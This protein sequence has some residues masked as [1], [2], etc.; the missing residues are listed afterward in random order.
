MKV[1]ISADME[2]TAGIVDSAQTA[3]PDR[4]HEFGI[5]NSSAEFE[6]ARR[7]M[8][9]E[10]NAAVAGALEGGATEVWVTDAHGSMRNL[11]PLALH[12]E[13]RYVGGRP[14][15]L[16]QLEGLDNT[17]GAVL[18]TGYHGRAGTP[19]SILAHTYIGI[20]QGIRL[21]GV[22]V[23]E[24]GVNA[25]LAGYF[26]V[27]VA[28]VTGDNTVVAQVRDLLGPDVVGVEV[29][30]A[31][32]TTAAASLHPEKARAAIRAGAAEAVR[33][34]PRLRPFLPAPPIRLEVDVTKPDLADLASL[35]KGVRR[36]GSHGIAYE[37]PDMMDVWK[38][39]L[40][41]RN[42]MNSRMP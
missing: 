4:A 37:G 25:A 27:P 20:I 15:L 34:A 2:G 12:P 16:G 35:C 42:V 41:M 32:S 29:K 33:R 36:T 19:A 3:P 28:L 22:P 10:A 11:L 13:A 14:K 39:W 17:F 21:G 24:Y 9:E 6:W 8:T 30:K 26:G 1:L 23:G 31:V 5:Q 38:T 40:V 7:L 18:F